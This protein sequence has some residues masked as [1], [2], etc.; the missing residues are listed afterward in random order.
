MNIYSTFPLLAI[1]LLLVGCASNPSQQKTVKSKSEVLQKLQEI[2]AA[3]VQT[4]QQ[5]AAISPLEKKSIIPNIN[6]E[7]QRGDIA[8]KML[9]KST[10]QFLEA[11]MNH[12]YQIS[13]E[14]ARQHLPFVS[15]EFSR[16]DKNEDN[17]VSWQE[18]LGH[19][20]WPRPVHENAIR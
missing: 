7:G 5:R 1:T 18:L 13:A 16:Y 11:D 2:Q 3:P 8:R 14:E 10:S 15:K 12:D 4:Q 6:E 9:A 20:K 17:T 19:D